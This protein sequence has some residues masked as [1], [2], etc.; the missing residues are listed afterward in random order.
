[1]SRA[2]YWLPGL[3]WGQR[4]GD[5]GTVDAMVGALTDP[6]DDCHMGITAENVAG[7][8]GISREDQDA[9]AVESHHRAAAATAEGRFAG[10][11]VPVELKSR[12]GSTFFSADEHTRKLLQA[13]DDPAV[14]A[15][16]VV[17]REDT[18]GDK[19]LVAYLTTTDAQHEALETT[20][21]DHLRRTL[22]YYMVPAAFVVLAALPLTPNGKVD[23]R[24]LPAPV[25][26]QH[27]LAE[28]FT[29]PCTPT[30]VQVATIWCEVLRLERAGIHDDFFALG[31]HSLLATQVISRCREA[32][33]VE[34]A[35]LSL[36]EERTIAGLAAR[37][38]HHKLTQDLQQT[39]ATVT[40]FGAHSR[41]ALREEIAL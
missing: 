39:V 24:A 18:P 27:D 7:K 34:I 17:V 31:G 32:F 3:R 10:Q 38:D 13:V 1:M 4:M 29:P 8:W 30:E 5:G 12:K 28:A 9:L 36:F 16:V 19:R 41:A 21:S 35:L 26:V 37:I 6:F 2:Q 22:P 15:T 23:R 20:L 11:I 25:A 33:G 40:D 14:R